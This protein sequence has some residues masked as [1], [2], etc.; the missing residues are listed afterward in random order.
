MLL[1]IIIILGYFFICSMVISK[2]RRR[3]KHAMYAFILTL[4]GHTYIQLFKLE[5]VI[6][7]SRVIELLQ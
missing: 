1:L 5:H 3:K 7:F 4:R 2:K 6:I